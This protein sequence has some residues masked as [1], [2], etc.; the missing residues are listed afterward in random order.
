MEPWVRK[1]PWRRKEQTTPV[2]LPGK[3]HGQRSLAEYS[4]WGHEESDTT[5]QLDIDTHVPTV[6]YMI[7]M[8]MWNLGKPVYGG[9]RALLT[10]IYFNH[11][12]HM[13]HLGKSEK[14]RCNF[15]TKY[16]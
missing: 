4:P 11:L 1:I 10:V 9:C 7:L 16:I 14:Y 15:F 2:F 6:C 12:D 5:E 3:S 8:V 13:T